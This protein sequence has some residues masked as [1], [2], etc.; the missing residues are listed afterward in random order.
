VNRRAAIATTIGGLLT[1]YPQISAALQAA[2]TGVEDLADQ[3]AI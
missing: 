1:G 3:S 2:N